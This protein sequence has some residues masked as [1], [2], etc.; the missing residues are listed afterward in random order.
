LN[1]EKEIPLKSFGCLISL[2][3]ESLD[4]EDIDIII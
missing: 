3:S 4:I 2:I 1:L